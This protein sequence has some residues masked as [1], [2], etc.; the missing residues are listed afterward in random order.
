MPLPKLSAGLS[1]SSRSMRNLVGSGKAA[2]SKFAAPIKTSTWSFLLKGV[3]AHFSPGCLATRRGF[4][5]K[6]ASSRRTSCTNAGA[7]RSTSTAVMLAASVSVASRKTMLAKAFAE[8][9]LTINCTMSVKASASWRSPA[10]T[11]ARMPGTGPPREGSTC[12]KSYS[13]KKYLGTNCTNSGCH[14]R[15][16]RGCF[17]GKSTVTSGLMI[18]HVQRKPKRQAIASV[19]GRLRKRPQSTRAH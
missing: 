10:S 16:I 18:C 13:A 8:V 4:R 11:P 9:M 7:R 6:G 14:Q 2:G 17:G 3:L 1:P 19:A 12:S 5:C 15:P